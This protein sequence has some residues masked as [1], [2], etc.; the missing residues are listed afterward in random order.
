M[1]ADTT[2]SAYNSAS[3]KINCQLQTAH[4]DP[5]R[6]PE[7]ST[8]LLCSGEKREIYH[9][10]FFLSVFPSPLSDKC[11]LQFHSQPQ[12]GSMKF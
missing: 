2:R 9:M 3:L 12:A 5:L 11:K 8:V 7:E 6:C 10:P 1:R 4:T